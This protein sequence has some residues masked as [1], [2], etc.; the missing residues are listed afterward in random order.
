M[1]K[2][3][4]FALF[5]LLSYQLLSLVSATPIAN[6]C[7]KTHDPR[8]CMNAINTFSGAYPATINAQ[9]MLRMHLSAISKRCVSAKTRALRMAKG[10]GSSTRMSLKTCAELYNNAVDLIGVSMRALNAN[11]GQ[12]GQM[13]QI[14]LQE[15]RQSAQQCDV[16]FQ[17]P[18]LSNPLSHV[19]GS[20]VK[21]TVNADDLNNLMNSNPN[22]FH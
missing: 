9:A 13:V 2:S 17:R 18:G 20:I 3:V 16:Q 1:A 12:T 5:L 15:I 14:M 11:D 7:G 6:F 22:L 10:A 4:Q 19:S 21:M 8:L